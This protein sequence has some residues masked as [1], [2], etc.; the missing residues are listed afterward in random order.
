MARFASATTQQLHALASALADH[1]QVSLGAL[2]GRALGKGGFFAGLARG[3]DCTTAN[4]E[5]LRDWFAERWP[6]DLDWRAAFG[7]RPGVARIADAEVPAAWVTEFDLA[8]L[9]TDPVWSNGRR[10]PWWDDI[11][12]RTFLTTAHRQM[13]ILRAAKVGAS[14]FG[15][16]CPK[17][18]AIGEYWK[19]LDAIARRPAP[20]AKAAAPT[21]RKT[22]KAA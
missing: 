7:V 19:R 9:S 15:D 10:P 4:A 8:S 22:R 17:K 13:S 6:A 3:A 21:P 18:S 5:R 16:R 12:V 2:S 20:V 11:E 14:R 1:E